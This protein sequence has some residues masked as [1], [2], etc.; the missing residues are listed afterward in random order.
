LRLGTDT[1]TGAVVQVDSL[2]LI[3]AISRRDTSARDTRVALFRLPLTL[4]STTTFADVAGDFTAPPLRSVNIDSLIALPTR[5]DTV[6]GDS[7]V[8]DTTTGAVTVVM[9]FDSSEVGYTVADSGKLGFGIRVSADTAAAPGR[10][11]LAFGAGD[12]GPILSWFVRVDS[13]GFA[14]VPRGIGAR[15]V[16]DTY[17]FDPP[18][19]P[20]DSSL[21]VGGVPSARSLLRVT[22]P[23]QLRDSTQVIRA[24]LVLVPVQALAGAAADS[25][26]LLAQRVAA[27][28]GAKSPLAGPQFPG[29]DAYFGATRVLPGVMDT[30]RIDITAVVR[31]WQADTTLPTLEFLRT[32]AEGGTVG[33]IRF[34]STRFPALRPTLQVTYV[35]RFPFGLP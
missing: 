21:A 9:R 17:V 2:R 15:A 8:V 25:V 14:T 27:D 1:L 35:P 22:V 23:Q 16:F 30:V 6:T 26:R 4:D 19:A 32:D 5:K 3:L 12:A 7:V 24:T 29:D 10:A 33:E 31:R 20:L 18:P 11:S 28:I 34:A 13:L